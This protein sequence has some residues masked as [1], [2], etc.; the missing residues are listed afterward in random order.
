MPGG[1]REREARPGCEV[2][3]TPLALPEMFQQFEPVSVAE[4]LRDYGETSE[5]LLFRAGR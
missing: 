4:R 5:N 2:F 3:D 1:V